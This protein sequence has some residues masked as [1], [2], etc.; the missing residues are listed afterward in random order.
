[1]ETIGSCVDKITI[2]ETKRYHMREQTKRKDVDESHINECCVKLE[3]INQ[4]L[5]DLIEELDA[6]FEDILSGNRKLKVYRQYK[7]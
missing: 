5:N 3:V 4:Q 1:M 7:M 6:Y 2:M